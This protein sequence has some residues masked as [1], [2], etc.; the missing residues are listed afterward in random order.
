METHNIFEEDRRFNQSLTGTERIR[1][2]RLEP[3]LN[4]ISKLFIFYISFFI[5]KFIIIITISYIIF[6]FVN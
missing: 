6:I 5:Y 4:S 3:I 1:N 2:E